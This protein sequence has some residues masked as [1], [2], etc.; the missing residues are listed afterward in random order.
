MEGSREEALQGR[1]RADGEQNNESL[2][3]SIRVH[4]EFLHSKSAASVV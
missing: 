1:G 3:A 2:P 4:V